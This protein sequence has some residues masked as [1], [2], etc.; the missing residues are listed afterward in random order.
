MKL[1]RTYYGGCCGVIKLSDENEE[2]LLFGN[3]Y[4][5]KI[6]YMIEGYLEALKHL[7]IEYEIEKR[8]G[9]C[10]Y[11]DIWDSE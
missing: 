10:Y 3:S 7:G 1:I 9:K 5:D 4:H 11:C 2:T 8:E 6:E